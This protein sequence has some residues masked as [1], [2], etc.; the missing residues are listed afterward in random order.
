M[1]SDSKPGK[2]NRPED[3]QIWR[4][5]GHF[6]NVDGDDIFVHASGKPAS[7]GH[8][9]LLTH[10]YPA[11]S[12]DWKNVVPR[13]AQHTRVVISD[14][15][16]FGQ[17]DK[18]MD[19]TF[20]S[21]YSMFKQADRVIA[22]AESEG[23]KEV[24]FCIHDMG[25]TVGAE[26]MARHEEGKLPFKIK[27]AIILNGSTMVDMV[28]FMEI[29]EKMLAAPDHVLEED[30]PDSSWHDLFTGSFSR[31]HQPNQGL[32]DVMIA[33]INEKHGSRLMPR[34]MRYQQERKD[35]LERWIGGLTKLSAPTS[36]FWG[37]QDPNGIEAM[38][39]RMKKLNPAADLH[40]WPD[41]S[42]WP[43]V[44]VPERVAK[45]IIDRL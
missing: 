8:G 7:E 35:N 21:H 18:P 23:L 14:F 38:A 34:L 12:I 15:L 37:Q 25:Q 9:V 41:V 44:E 36:I 24:V 28:H 22:V 19:G 2:T 32:L 27:H 29:Q 20:E 11:S 43:P 16:G 39:D 4:D 13:V 17:S 30:M 42:H 10:G 26:I 6:L 31:E 3:L 45:A 40:K 33:Q 1:M 5:E